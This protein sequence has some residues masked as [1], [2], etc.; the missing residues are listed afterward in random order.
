V[1]PAQGIP[2]W[3]LP[4]ASGASRA[5]PA[6][7]PAARR[8][9]RSV[10]GPGCSPPAGSPGRGGLRHLDVSLVLAVASIDVIGLVMIYSATHR[11]LA[12]QHGDPAYYVKRQAAFV[13]GGAV[14][15]AMTVL[16]DYRRWRAL[17]PLVYLATCL[18]LVAVVSPL[19]ASSKGHQ[20][21]FSL[22][23][24]QFQPSELSKVALVVCLAA[25][26]SWSGQRTERADEPALS[27]ARFIALIALAGVPMGLIMLQPDLGTDLVYGAILVAVLVVA[28]MR[29][30]HLVALLVLGTVGAVAVLQLGVLQRYQVDRLT[31]F[32]D[33][34]GKTSN[35]GY[36]LNESM[37]AI[38]S[39][40]ALGKG[41]LRGPQTNL[42]YVPE[43]HTDFIFTAV[44]EQGGLVGSALVLGLFAFVVWRIWRAAALARDRTGTLMCVGVLALVVFQVFENVGM[45]TGIMPIAGIPLPFLSYGGSA[46]M[47]YSVGIGL[48]LNIHMRRLT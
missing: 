12:A 38:G 45:T 43:Q 5:R 9:G 47:A 35:A 34:S 11:R 19:G 30:R 4:P 33:A 14:L 10:R 7:A 36:S 41:L 31:S 46:V 42:S 26:A 17:A 23:T 1:R 2:A 3:S 37:L 28:G 39:G 44:G 22:G 24:F 15:A 25:G 16:V 40:G 29:G 32:L 48:V 8:G 13:V 6:P 20:A 18:A 21:W 27:G